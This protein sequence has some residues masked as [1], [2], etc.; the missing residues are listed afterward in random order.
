MTKKEIVAKIAEKL[1]T[2]H[3]GTQRI[4]QETLDA[5][6]ETLLVEGRAELRNFGVFEVKRRAARIARNPKTGVK[7]DVPEKC[8]VTFRPGKVM[9][10]KVA[11]LMEAKR[12]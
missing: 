7:V 10:E 2:S 5:V 12:E 8:V 9:E 4:V 1:G 3:L 6:I 11:E